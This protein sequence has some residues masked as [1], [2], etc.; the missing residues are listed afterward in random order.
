MWQTLANTKREPVLN[1]TKLRNKQRLKLKGIDVNYS[2]SNRWKNIWNINLCDLWIEPPI[3]EI[4]LCPFWRKKELIFYDLSG[5]RKK[6]EIPQ[7]GLRHELTKSQLF[8]YRETVSR[9]KLR[10]IGKE[11]IR[12]RGMLTLIYSRLLTTQENYWQWFPSR[13]RSSRCWWR[14][15]LSLSHYQLAVST[16]WC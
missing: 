11:K 15:V 1:L 3:L 6:M 14:L 4:R 13:V 2:W 9:L 10:K 7:H 16:C 8:L 12:E 5:P